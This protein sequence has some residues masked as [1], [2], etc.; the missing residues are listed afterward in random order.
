MNSNLH[1]HLTLFIYHHH[2]PSF[3]VCECARCT[4][5]LENLNDCS[6][7]FECSSPNIP[8]AN[9]LTLSKVCSNLSLFSVKNTLIALNNT[10]T[11]FACLSLFYFF[12]IFNNFIIYYGL[13]IDHIFLFL[14]VSPAGMQH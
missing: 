10:S 14:S 12:V 13:I 11:S 7:C 5:V 4:R 8:L 9:S 2:P 1:K 3:Q 6:L